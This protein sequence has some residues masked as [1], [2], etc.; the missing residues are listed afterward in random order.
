MSMSAGNAKYKFQLIDMENNKLIGDQD[1]NVAHEKKLH[2][3]IYD[4]S[5]QEFQHV[6]PEFDGTMWVVDTQFSVDGNYWI[7][8]QGELAADGEEFS[9]S[10]RLDITGGATAWP[11]PLFL[12]ISAPEHLACRQLSLAKT[13]SLRARWQCSI[14]R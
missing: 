3:I 12:E 4:P 13:S 8:A 11:T 5:L 2:L 7:W 9:T 10:N 6:H 14:S 1:L